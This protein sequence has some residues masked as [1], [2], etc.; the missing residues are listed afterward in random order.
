[1]IGFVDQAMLALQA[2]LVGRD[3]YG[4]DHPSVISQADRAYG[5]LSQALDQTEEVAVIVLTDRLV[6]GSSMLGSSTELRAGLIPRLIR[7]GV[8]C[9]RFKQGLKR[10]EVIQ[11]LDQLE[12]AGEADGLAESPHIVLGTVLAKSAIAEIDDS[13]QPTADF[14]PTIQETWQDFGRD[15]SPAMDA[16]G[17]V[18][19]EITT[20]VSSDSGTLLPLAGLKSHDEYT[21][22]H[23]INV[24][25]LTSALGEAVGL[26]GQ[27]LFDLT[28][29]G[30]LHDIGKRRTP[31]ELLNK[32]GKL[33][34]AERD[35][36]QKHPADGAEILLASRNVPKVAVVVAFEH[37]MDINGKGYPGA[38]GPWRTSMASQIV[39]IVDIFDALRTNRPYRAAMST[40]KAL[41]IISERSGVGFDPDLF[42]VFV[43]HV[44]GRVGDG[45]QSDS[46]PIARAA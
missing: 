5:L 32:S 36:I 26:T 2:S 33:T 11:L 23:T 42:G 27:R 9:L 6:V 35:I 28:T 12:A 40:E 44:L 34:A 3:F 10:P 17:N 21:F 7:I 43:S 1:M 16:L 19:S 38:R 13:A 4:R 45:K 14:M 24:G 20:V 30:L 37:H 25:V 41:E 31:T 8:E 46:D 39:Q 22:V 15:D 29:A 18:V